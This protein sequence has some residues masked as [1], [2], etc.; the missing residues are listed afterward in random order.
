MAPLPRALKGAALL[1]A[2]A[3]LSGRPPVAAGTGCRDDTR[4]LPCQ[5][6]GPV[7][8]VFIDGAFRASE[9]VPG[10][11]REVG[12]GKAGCKTCMQHTPVSGST[13]GW[14]VWE[15]DVGRCSGGCEHLSGGLGF[16]VCSY[17][18]EKKPCVEI[19]KRHTCT[20]RACVPFTN[21][22]TPQSCKDVPYP[23]S[24]F[25]EKCL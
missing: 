14:S 6:R 17:A 19:R 3:V 5:G 12:S 16:G 10:Q 15:S 4:S 24:G 20:P 2:A 23:W 1:L 18:H 22:C 11:C 7:G 9:V 13:N 8:H 25:N 21:K